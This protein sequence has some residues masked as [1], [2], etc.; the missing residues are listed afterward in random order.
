M[1]A[2]GALIGR[3]RQVMHD[4]DAIVGFLSAL[5]DPASDSR[6]EHS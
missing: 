3:I 6:A 4:M 2:N 5:G 1:T